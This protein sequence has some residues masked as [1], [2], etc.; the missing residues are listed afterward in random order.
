ML[1]LLI[2]LSIFMIFCGVSQDFVKVREK[3]NKDLDKSFAQHTIDQYIDDYG[4]R[5][6]NNFIREVH[7]FIERKLDIIYDFIQQYL[8]DYYHN[9][10][11]SKHVSRVDIFGIESISRVV[12]DKI[13]L[14]Y[15][16]M[17]ADEDADYEYNW[18]DYEIKI[19]N[20]F[21]DAG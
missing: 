2:I 14:K 5:I 1:I 7:N 8:P 4:D 10:I 20:L 16:Q 3:Y 6:V 21:I 18:L 9:L 19:T 11:S 17:D 12:I 13:L 15:Y